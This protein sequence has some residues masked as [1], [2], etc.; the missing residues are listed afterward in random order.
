LY[1]ERTGSKAIQAAFETSAQGAPPGEVN[2]ITFMAI[3]YSGFSQNICASVDKYSDTKYS[4]GP[5]LGTK[6]GDTNCSCVGAC[7]ASGTSYYII[8][9]QDN[10][11]SDWRD[12][13]SKLRIS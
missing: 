2:Q 12:F 6:I 13:I 1:I 11:I 9:S 4:L 8:S 10:V 3:N 7:G 5:V